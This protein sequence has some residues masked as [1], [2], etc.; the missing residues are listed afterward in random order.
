MPFWLMK[1]EPDLFSIDDL[2]RVKREPWVGVR[3]YQA[4]NFM[5]DNMQIGELAIFYHSNASPPG[6]HG[7]MRIATDPYDD[8]TQLDPSHIY[9]D[10][11][12]SPDKPRWQ[13]VDVEY[14]CH[15]PTPVSL[16]TMRDTPALA[17]MRLLQR[18]NR[19]S[20]L[21]LEQDEL[22]IILSLGGLTDEQID[23]YLSAAEP[24]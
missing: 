23:A 10:P 1:S 5:R 19:L 13:L 8:P 20:I 3:N 7:L 21:P 18:G 17:N 14:I 11:K 16:Q 6:A 24:T 2:E 15:L 4:R 12:S 9:Y 22:R